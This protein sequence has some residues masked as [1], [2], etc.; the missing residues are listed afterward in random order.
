MR[1]SIIYYLALILYA[2][3]VYVM[4]LERIVMSHNGVLKKRIDTH[5]EKHRYTQRDSGERK[6]W[7]RHGNSSFFSSPLPPTNRARGSGCVRRTITAYPP[8][9]AAFV[10]AAAT[11]AR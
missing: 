9:G 2:V 3:E 4:F 6:I 1:V 8:A 10:A 5:D 11:G 7:S